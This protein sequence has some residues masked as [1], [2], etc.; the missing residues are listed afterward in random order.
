MEEP[1]CDFLLLFTTS[2][3]MGKLS[4]KL[5]AIFQ[6]KTKDDLI[7]PLTWLLY[8]DIGIGILIVALVISALVADHELIVRTLI[9]SIYTLCPMAALDLIRHINLVVLESNEKEAEETGTVHTVWI[10]K[11]TK[12]VGMLWL[13][14]PIFASFFVMGSFVDF[15]FYVDHERLSEPD[16]H[17]NAGCGVSIYGAVVTAVM[18]LTSLLYILSML[19]VY[20]KLPSLKDK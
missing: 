17:C 14:P 4:E 2:K 15:L 8:A 19:R 20:L 1:L 3:R 12:D 6:V 13:L 5:W 10:H 18:V 9:L 7:T 16:R 11:T